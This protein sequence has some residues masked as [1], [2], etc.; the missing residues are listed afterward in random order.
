MSLPTQV[1][2]PATS[3][4]EFA[5]EISSLDLLQGA[6]SVGLAWILSPQ[7]LVWVI[8]WLL[9]TVPMSL[10]I[11]FRDK[12]RTLTCIVIILY[13]VLIPL[14]IIVIEI[15]A[16]LDW[17]LPQTN[18]RYQITFLNTGTLILSVTN[19]CSPSRWSYDP[20]TPTAPLTGAKLSDLDQATTL[21]VG[22]FA[23]ILIF[24][25][26]VTNICHNYLRSE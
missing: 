14:P 23:L 9:T 20:G 16:A 8:Q 7:T 10:N 3:S 26:M 25:N 4:K 17:Q 19:I 5:R 21:M 18:E 11:V 13:C 2:P 6:L 15:F 1:S 22:L 12:L 24:T